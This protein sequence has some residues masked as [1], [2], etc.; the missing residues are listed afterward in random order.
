MANGFFPT[1]RV[2][3]KVEVTLE[4]EI[5]RDV[6]FPATVVEDLGNN[7]FLVEY[8]ELQRVSIDH[9]HIRPSA[10]QF[11]VTSFGLLEKVDAFYDFGW[12]SGV[13]T[14]KLTDSRY[15]V[16]FKQTNKVKE[17]SHLELRP[18]V[19]WK[20]DGWFTTRQP[21]KEDK[22]VDLKPPMITSAR[23][24]GK[25]SADSRGP[26]ALHNTA[27]DL[28]LTTTTPNTVKGKPVTENTPSPVVIGLQCKALTASQ[29]KTSK[30]L[31]SKSPQNVDEPEAPQSSLLLASKIVDVQDK[32]TDGNS[33]TIRKWGKT[34]RR[35]PTN[36]KTSVAL[37]NQNGDASVKKQKEKSN[38][39]AKGKRGRNIISLNIESSPQD[40]HDS[41]AQIVLVNGTSDIVEK[42]L[43][44]VSENQSL[45]RLFLASLESAGKEPSGNSN[46]PLSITN[47]DDQKPSFEKRSSFWETIGSME[48]F[49]LFPQN[50]HFRP[51]DTLNES[52]RERH[53]IYKMVDFSGVFE[54]MCRLRRDHP[55]TEFQD[56]L[57]I[58]LELETHG[59]D[60]HS[61]RSRLMEMLSCKD[62]REAL[63]TGSKDPE[64]HLEIECVK[65]QERKI[66]IMLIDCQINELREKRERLVKENE[67]STMNIAAWEKE[68]AEI[69]EAKCECDR[70]F[71]ELANARY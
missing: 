32:E 66:H 3:K 42:T 54:N 57:E 7:R 34:F 17:F 8:K 65:V 56:Q 53:A 51:L 19:E 5:L 58:L 18:H 13:I 35:Q 71:Y 16:Y 60:V 27:G 70:K 9:L 1:Y 45:S 46:I 24:K 61:L 37:S 33:S 68:V 10:P 23:K 2:G 28:T 59:F 67:E 49:R 41:S 63:E 39:P 12:W 6:W 50:P 21:A 15:V 43:D 40:L 38:T 4:E 47:G 31:I 52:A 69:E 14:K 20:D 55:R 36:R 48:A 44:L 29:T 62:K 22:S 30:R 64:D 11:T 26:K 25:L